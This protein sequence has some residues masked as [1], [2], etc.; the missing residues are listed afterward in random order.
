[1]L[2]K[3]MKAF[4]KGFSFREISSSLLHNIQKQQQQNKKILTNKKT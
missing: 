1:M 4:I 3:K 2:K